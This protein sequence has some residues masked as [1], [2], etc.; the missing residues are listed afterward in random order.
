MANA[1]RE[2]Q[3]AN[4]AKKQEQ[5]AVVEEKQAKRG[6]Y[7][8]W[9]LLGGLLVGLILVLTYCASRGDD[10][11][12]VETIPTSSESS[13]SSADEGDGDTS[14]EGA[15]SD[16]AAAIPDGP[17]PADFTPWSESGELS[18]STPALRNGI[19]DAAP[20]M[21]IDTAKDYEAI[22]NTNRGS[23]RFT[24]FDDE[25][26]ITVNNFVM[27]ARDGF[28]DGTTFHRVLQ[29]FMAQGGDPTGTGTGGPGYAFEDEVDTGLSFD[30]RGQLAM[31]NSGANTNGSQFFI[32]F[33]PTTHLTGLHTI[34]GELT[35]G[36]D[37]LSEIRLRDPAAG[38]TEPGDVITSIEIVES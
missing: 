21:T 37:V 15:D 17:V 4:R 36:D 14:D 2:R 8:N 9:L 24:L 38:D 7:T 18:D 3:R 1:K 13:E 29:D 27:L 6:Q 32:T 16:A 34:Y 12:E 11:Q 22:I 19:Y 5:Q 25:A 31:A 28:Y 30:A 26:P 20:P 23:M 35:D 33:V 10:D